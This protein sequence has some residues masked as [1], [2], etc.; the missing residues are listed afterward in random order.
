MSEKHGIWHDFQVRRIYQNGRFH[1]GTCLNEMYMEG[2]IANFKEN[3]AQYQVGPFD[4]RLTIEKVSGQAPE[5]MVKLQT[6]T[7]CFKERQVA[8]AASVFSIERRRVDLET[9]HSEVLCKEQYA[10]EVLFWAD[11][12]DDVR[13]Y[14]ADI[15]LQSCNQRADVLEFYPN[16]PDCYGK[17]EFD[18]G[19]L[20]AG[21]LVMM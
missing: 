3:M 16:E 10:V 2:L 17:V 15:F 18:P 11:A 13:R 5:E 1:N 21:H 9:G 19:A 20:R 12:T 8:R 6:K 14:L 7:D 4:L